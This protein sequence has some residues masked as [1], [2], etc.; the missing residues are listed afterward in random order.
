VDRS[1]VAN[2]RQNGA[3]RKAV[4]VCTDVSNRIYFVGG[5]CAAISKVCS[6]TAANG[7]PRPPWPGEGARAICALACRLITAA[8]PERAWTGT[9]PVSRHTNRSAATLSS[10]Q[11][12]VAHLPALAPLVQQIPSR[13]SALSVQ[14]SPMSDVPLQVPH[15]QLPE[16]QSN[17]E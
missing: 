3:P 16:R 15:T 7:L 8:C 9:V 14:E 4:G 12:L 1:I 10:H 11:Q 13:Q 17:P 5:I 6:A 2:G